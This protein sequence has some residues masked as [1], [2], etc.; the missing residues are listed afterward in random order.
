M[1]AYL[2]CGSGISGD[3]FLGA[4]IGAGFSA[5]ALAETVA[6]LDL[7][8]FELT[9]EATSR[10]GIAAVGV[11]VGCG[12]QPARRWADIRALLE[13]SSLVEAVKAGALAAFGE[14]AE[15]EAR[16]HGV[17]V[18]HVHFHEVGAV[19][20]IVDIVGV[21]A[22]LAALGVDELVVSPVATGFGTVETSH[23]T[24][25]VPAPATAELLVGV[26][27][28]AG[29]VEGELTTPT[30]AVLVRTFAS[31]FGRMPLAV[32]VAVGYGA[33]SRELPVPNVARLTLAESVAAEC[34]AADSEGGIGAETVTVLETNI[35]H[36]TPEHLAFVAERLLEAGALDVWRTPIVMKKGRAA[37][38]LSVMVPSDAAGRFSALVMELT[39]AL[40]V[41][42]ATVTR[43]VVP[44]II[45]SVETSFGPVRVKVA[46]IAGARRF[47]PEF[48]DVAEIARREGIPV[49]EVA[50]LLTAEA[51]EILG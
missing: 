45:A 31:G 26:P 48:D 34:D 13:G 5:D 30:G 2:D 28:Y 37:A 49:D 10:G 47:R 46:T 20:S 51:E 11:T 44:R 42:R 14:L 12:E 22:G 41:R 43:D 33:G 25:P 18:D 38:A 27:S 24:L 3:K 16:V 8:D 40:G 19:D 9:V 36:L 23:G 21:A 1:L 50:R 4:L 29:E 6:T 7:G 15:A 17:S 32:P 39:G 35:D